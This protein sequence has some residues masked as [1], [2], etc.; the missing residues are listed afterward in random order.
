MN[1]S[2]KNIY[3]LVVIFAMM[4]V[5]YFEGY[6]FPWSIDVFAY[7]VGFSL[8]PVLIGGLAKLIAVICKYELSFQSWFN[9]VGTLIFISGLLQTLNL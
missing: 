2:N 8:T 4:S 1:M 3:S 6:G 5:P 9:G 7:A